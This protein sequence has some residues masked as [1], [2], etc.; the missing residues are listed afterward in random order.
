[1]TREEKVLYHQIHP[2]K[3]LTGATA[4]FAALPLLRRHRLRAALLVTLVPPILS[5]ILVI[6]YADLEPYRRS[7]FGRY[8][9]RYMT[10]EMQGVRLAGY[11]IMALGSW[12]RRPWSVPLGLLVVLF[13]WSRGVL[14]PRRGG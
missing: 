13:G 8:V 4:G 1:M 3:L 5:S 6:R 9:E 11:L 7:A 10:R 2:L 12:Y 14:F